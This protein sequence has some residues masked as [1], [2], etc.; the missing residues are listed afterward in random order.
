MRSLSNSYGYTTGGDH[1]ATLNNVQTTNSRGGGRGSFAPARGNN[2][3]LLHAHSLM[4]TW[5][6]CLL[7]SMI[8]QMLTCLRLPMLLVPLFHSMQCLIR[9]CN[10]ELPAVSGSLNVLSPNGL[11]IMFHGMVAVNLGKTQSEPWL[12]P[13]QA[14]VTF[15]S[16]LWGKL[17]FQSVHCQN[18]SNAVSNGTC[19]LSFRHTVL[20][21]SN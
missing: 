1:N 20:L 21:W 5:H 18:G 15:P 16:H 7:H 12:T 4:P 19:T 9:L 6:A 3:V 17:V 13:E 10:A 2:A 11:T 14:I 8:T